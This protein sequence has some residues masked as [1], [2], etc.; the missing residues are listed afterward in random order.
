MQT[1]FREKRLG[2]RYRNKILV[3]FADYSKVLI[4]AVVKMNGD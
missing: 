2:N 4:L 3:S 1:E